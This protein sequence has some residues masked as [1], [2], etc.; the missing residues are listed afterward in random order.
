MFTDLKDTLTSQG[1]RN[2]GEVLTEPFSMSESD[3]RIKADVGRASGGYG[4]KP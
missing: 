3:Q 1:G 2:Y 4:T